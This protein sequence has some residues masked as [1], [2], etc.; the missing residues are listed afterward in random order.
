MAEDTVRLALEIADEAASIDVGAYGR[1]CP[2]QPRA[3]SV[4]ATP[5]Q[6]GPGRFYYAV[7]QQMETD[8]R[9]GWRRRRWR[10]NSPL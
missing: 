10:L 6:F 3:G 2:R 1:R 9:L 5:S 7:I 8:Q 4:P